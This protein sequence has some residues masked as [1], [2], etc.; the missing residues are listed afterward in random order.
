MGQGKTG[1]GVKAPMG[2][3]NTGPGVKAPMDQ[4]KTGPGVK[5]PMGNLLP[6]CLSSPYHH[7]TVKYQVKVLEESISN[8]K[9]VLGWLKYIYTRR[10]KESSC[11]VKNHDDA[12]R[13]QIGSV[14]R[15]GSTKVL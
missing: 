12:T 5:A 14:T 15:Q 10:T 3:G 11:Y 4:G 2:Q 6:S 13:S 9:T 8:Q 7:D 1:P